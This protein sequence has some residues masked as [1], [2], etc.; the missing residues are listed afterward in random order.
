MKQMKV[1]IAGGGT[2]GHIFPAVAIGHAVQRLQPDA[3]LLFVGAQG[4]MEMEKVPQEGFNIIGLDIAGFNR[5]NMLKN[6]S[7]P[8]KLI[9]SIFKANSILKNFKPD[10]VVGVGGYASFPILKAAQR[11]GIPTVIQEQNSFAGKSNQILARKAAAICVAYDQ[12]DKF[13]PKEKIIVTGNPVRKSI[14]Q[15]TITRAEGQQW[16]GMD[17]GKK[18]VLVIGGSL[19]AKAINEAI[20]AHL[21]EIVS[22]KVQLIWQTGKPYYEQAVE[23]AKAFGDKVKVFDFIR[24][25][26]YAYA[27]ADIVIS[28]AGAL[29]IA[30][31]CIAAKPVI[32]V[33]YPFAAE[34]HQTSNAMALVT[35]SAALMVKDGEAKDLLVTKL[36]TLL[37]DQSMQQVMTQN[38]EKAAIKDADERIAK[39]LIALANKG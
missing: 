23:R 15:S 8:F 14:A 25:M 19:G 20:D 21:D 39:K 6:I 32:F 18:T 31:L 5:S 2:G 10:V 38:L 16:L 33:P 13:F 22:D 1:I 17:A 11:M 28:R 9:K 7:L 24:Q 36:N 29:A 4:K 12:M 35:Q 27:A 37:H 26:D 30:E 3:E 34:D